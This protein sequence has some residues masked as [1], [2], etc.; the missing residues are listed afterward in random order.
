MAFTQ[1]V[2]IV[3]K[4]RDP[5]QGCPW[6]LVQTQKTLAQ[7]SIE[8]AFELAEAIE[9]EKPGLVLEELGDFLFQVILQAQVSAD[10][11][12]FNLQD[13]VE[14][15][16]EKM[17]RRHPHVFNAES[18]ASIEK[19]WQN[20]EK[21]KLQEKQQRGDSA[22]KVFSQPEKLPALQASAK[23]GAKTA[24]YKFDWNTPSEVLLKVK[25]EQAELEAELLKEKINLVKTENE[26][27][28]LL[29]S[30]SQLARHL[31]IDPEQALRGANRK[32]TN[33][34]NAMLE[35]KNMSAETFRDLP[36]ETKEE[37]WAL[38]KQNEER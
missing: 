2:D 22:Q 25:E 11:Q 29:F 36:S 6:D 27:G 37:L 18:S 24:R 12:G 8:E 10:N 1:L 32:F 7:Y 17:I 14:L 21:T 4:L 15:L 23:I 19:V 38:V 16:S 28:D 34:F 20:W 26:I 5:K 3:A 30:I 33:R 13:V 31:K 9:T 35:L